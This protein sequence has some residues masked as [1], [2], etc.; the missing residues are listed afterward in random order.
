LNNDLHVRR[1]PSGC[2]LAA[3]IAAAPARELLFFLTTFFL[4]WPEFDLNV[5]HHGRATPVAFGLAN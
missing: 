1:Y 3:A 4:H 2:S 5:L